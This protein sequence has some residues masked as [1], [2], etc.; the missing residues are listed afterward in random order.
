MIIGKILKPQ[1]I[2][3]ELKI[4]PQVDELNFKQ[5]KTVQIDEKTF[6]IKS[7]KLRDEYVFVEF[8]EIKNRNE[9]E[10]LRDK[11]ICAPQE[12]LLPLKENEYYVDD[13]IGC[14]IKTEDGEKLGKVFDVQNFGASDILTIRDGSEEILCPFLNKVFVDVDTQNKVIVVS[15]KH[16]LEVTQSEN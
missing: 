8:N 13:L 7:V 3:G 10:E 14:I 2:R 9:A 5:I 12:E 11:N 16:F 15:K 6:T 4:K 1:G